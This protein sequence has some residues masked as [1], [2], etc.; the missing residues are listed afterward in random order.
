MMDEATASID[1]T[2]DAKVQETI[3]ELKGNT[4]I[5]IAHRLKTIVDYDKVI[6]MERGRVVELG[7]PW[8]LLRDDGKGIT[9]DD[10]KRWFRE[11]C[12]TSGE[13]EDLV[14]EARRSH[15]QKRLVNDD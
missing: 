9:G 8:D 1:Y 14:S 7:S 5:T 12:E 3:K 15:E 2:T 6:V 10:G 11:M 4:I 13:L